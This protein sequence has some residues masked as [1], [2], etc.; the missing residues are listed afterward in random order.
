MRPPPPAPTP[1]SPPSPSAPGTTTARTTRRRI[2]ARPKT[3]SSGWRRRIRRCQAA[4]RARGG[5]PPAGYSSASSTSTGA[6]APWRSPTAPCSAGGPSS[7]HVVPVQH[8]AEPGDERAHHVCT[9]NI[10]DQTLLSIEVCGYIFVPK[11]I[12]SLLSADD[13]LGA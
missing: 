3:A 6:R 11:C 7:Q 10:S 5:Q 9:F 1:S 13:L 4:R 12:G 2:T 8:Q